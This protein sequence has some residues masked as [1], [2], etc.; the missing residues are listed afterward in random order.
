MKEPRAR[1]RVCLCVER[2]TKYMIDAIFFIYY[3]FGHD[4][5]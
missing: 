2:S 1:L 4:A 5:F 3:L